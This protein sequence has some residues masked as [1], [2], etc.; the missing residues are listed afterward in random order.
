MFIPIASSV[1]HRPLFWIDLEDDEMEIP[2]WAE[3]I[4]QK[5]KADFTKVVTFTYIQYVFWTLYIY[6][7]CIHTVRAANTPAKDL[8][9]NFS[10]FS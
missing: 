7:Y 3:P 6:M 5:P 1:F 8:H 4:T 2:V 9:L 10:V